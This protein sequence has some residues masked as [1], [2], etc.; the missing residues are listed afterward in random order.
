MSTAPKSAMA[1][2][3]TGSIELIIFFAASFTIAGRAL[4]A[5]RWLIGATGALANYGVNRRWAFA[6]RDAPKREQGLR[7]GLTAFGAVCIGTA[8]FAVLCAFE[9]DARLAHV[10]SMSLVWLGFTYPTM[11]RWVFA[12]PLSGSS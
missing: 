5:A 7:Y 2:V 1:S 8:L 11:K 10:V 4:I 6:N 3:M 9:V 12:E